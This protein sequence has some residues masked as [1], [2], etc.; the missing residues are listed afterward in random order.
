MDRDS[1]VALMHNLY[2]NYENLGGLTGQWEPE[3]TD[4][5]SNT[6]STST[7]P[8]CDNQKLRSDDN[9]SNKKDSNEN[10]T[11][12]R[13]SVCDNPE[14]P[15]FPR[16]PDIAEDLVGSPLKIPS[17]VMK[18][19]LE[20]T[21]ASDENKRSEESGRKEERCE[22]S[23]TGNGEGVRWVFNP[24]CYPNGTGRTYIIIILG[25]MVT[26]MSK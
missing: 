14:S 10:F 22:E 8:R 5:D 1:D 16:F 15:T 6:S 11:N 26:C 19:T 13:A 12:G 9:E 3:N 25:D 18:S 17:S 21:E 7:S 23:S 4:E 2:Y 24:F 20:A